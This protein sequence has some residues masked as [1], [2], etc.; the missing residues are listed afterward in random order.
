MGKRKLL[1][2]NGET[3]IGEG[4]GAEVDAVCEVVFNTSMVGYQEIYSDCSYKSQF[5]CMTYPLI[6]NYGLADEDYE[7]K[8]PVMGGLIVRE[9]NESLANFR[10]SKTLA[11]SMEEHGIPGIEGLD[12]RK[13]TRMIRSQGSM[14]AVLCAA[15]TP[16]ATARLMLA[17]TPAPHDQVASV[18][19]KKKWYARTAGVRFNV[20]AVDCGI[21][22]GI[23]RNLVDRNCNVTVVPFDTPAEK[24]LA[25][26]PDGLVLSNGP[27]DPQDVQPVISLVQQLQ[28]KLP[29]FGI[30]LGHQLIALANGCE[31]Y[32]L[33]FGHR[34]GNHPVK[35]LA[36]GTIE[37]TSQNHSYAVA[38]ESVK[39]T[40]LTPTHHNL[41]DGTLEGL[42]SASDAIFSVQF[43][44]ENRPG[45]QDSA[46]LFDKFTGLMERTRNGGPFYA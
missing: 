20:V 30:C 23:V 10:A 2:E 44:P 34:G 37:M 7:T 26:S 3:F 6:G 16:E 18:S 33:K 4:F 32:K 35:N 39:G 40:G 22:L 9:Y 12:T 15:D 11:E 45:P 42:E 28:G 21:K 25:L 17:G 27:G 41:L 31:T 46:W 1:F 13:I 24:I 38:E 19:C 5:V 29:I 8:T 43:H 14:R 36:T